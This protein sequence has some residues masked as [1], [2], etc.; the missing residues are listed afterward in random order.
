LGEEEV[1]GG[2]YRDYKFILH[3]VLG[4]EEENMGVCIEEGGTPEK[5]GVGGGE[6]LP[7]EY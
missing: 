2:L 6:K 3:R 4:G 7:K 5:H 1:S